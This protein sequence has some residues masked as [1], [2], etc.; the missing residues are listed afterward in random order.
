[1]TEEGFYGMD[2]RILNLF[3]MRNRKFKVATFHNNIWHHTH[4]QA[5]VTQKREFRDRSLLSTSSLTTPTTGYSGMK[6][7]STDAHS[8]YYPTNRFS[9]KFPTVK[10]ENPF[11]HCFRRKRTIFH[12]FPLFFTNSKLQK[13]FQKSI[14]FEFG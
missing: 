13:Q 10:R 9:T 6:T 2:G 1:M 3:Y 7:D 8:H 4:Q 5:S 12:P 14:I 11:S